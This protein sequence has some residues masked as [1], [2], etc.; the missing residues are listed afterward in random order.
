M[1]NENPELRQDGV[2]LPNNSN[3]GDTNSSHMRDRS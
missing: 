3:R 2:V 1:A